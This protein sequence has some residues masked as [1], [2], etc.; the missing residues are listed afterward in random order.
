[1]SSLHI[2][3]IEGLPEITPGADLAAVILAAA[4]GTGV[5]L[6][7]GDVLVVTSKIVSKAEGRTVEL[8]EI[9][10]SPFAREWSAKWD[11]DPAIVEIVLREAKRIVRQLGPILITETYHGFVCANSG[12]D[13]SSSGAHGRAVLLPVDPD[14]S[15][16]RIREGLRAAGLDVAVIIS[17]TFGRA[18][19]EG[20]T[21]IAIGIAGMQPI[22]SYIGQ[23]D[24]HGHEFLVQA[25]CTADELAAAAELV[26]GNVSRVPVALVRGHA[27]EPDDTATIAPVLRDQSK[28]L[29]R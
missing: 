6:A 27:W 21:D 3:G 12:V 15:A 10:P 14:A 4:E 18:W 9:E 20:Q 17:D 22:L 26:K 5:P 8:A 2:T 19:R 13:Q 11:K 16:R 1:M 25:L 7:D 28:D 23:V 29:F 24:P